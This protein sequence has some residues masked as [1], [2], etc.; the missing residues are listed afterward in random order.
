M[1]DVSILI[2]NWPMEMRGEYISVNVILQ[3]SFHPVEPN[4]DIDHT[5]VEMAKESSTYTDEDIEL[6]IKSDWNEVP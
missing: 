2:E 3:T 1:L 4:Y 6:R 5:I